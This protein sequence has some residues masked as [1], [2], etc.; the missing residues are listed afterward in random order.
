M[1][2]GCVPEQYKFTSNQ[3]T[4]P[5]HAATTRPLFW[6]IQEWRRGR[7]QA[8]SADAARSSV[9]AAPPPKMGG[10]IPSVKMSQVGS[11]A[12]PAD[13]FQDLCQKLSAT[14][15]W[16][17]GSEVDYVKQW[18][19]RSALEVDYEAVSSLRSMGGIIR[20]YET[21]YREG[22]GGA[23]PAAAGKRGGGS[24]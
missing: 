20:L 7:T 19:F 3:L 5:G 2:P 11:R 24:R 14:M 22:C 10:G 6:S 9:G 12:V 21:A 17:T 15:A 16:V 23:A 4:I 13:V 18:M 8:G 1:C